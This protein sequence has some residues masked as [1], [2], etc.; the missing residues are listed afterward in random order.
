MNSKHLVSCIK[1]VIKSKVKD[2]LGCVYLHKDQLTVADKENFVTIPFDSGVDACVPAG[3]F[4][5]TLKG[6]VRPVFAQPESTTVCISEGDVQETMPAINSN[7]FP[8]NFLNAGFDFHQIG[9]WT[10][11]ELSYLKK[12]LDFINPR[13]P[14]EAV[15]GI[16]AA[17]EIAST[18]GFRLYH[19]RI[20]HLLEEIIIPEKTA[21]ILLSFKKRNWKVF[22]GIY[23]VPQER[24]KRGKKQAPPAP[25]QHYG[26]FISEDGIVISFKPI[27]KR[28]FDY[29]VVIPDGTPLITIKVQAE[30]LLQCLKPAISNLAPGDEQVI[31]SVKGKSMLESIN[32]KTGKRY[33]QEFK[34]KCEFSYSD[35]EH[36]RIGFKG[37][38]LNSILKQIKKEVKS[39]REVTIQ[40]YRATTGLIINDHYLL[41]SSPISAN[42]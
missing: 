3:K 32:S 42:S 12:A 13:Y 16:K 15:Q 38:Y 41:I 23:V 20:E 33:E 4:C 26:A 6:M 24:P 29:K 37:V 34:C 40:L 30:P 21:R 35:D 25:P 28:Y 5:K 39:K 27:Q 36:F 19:P 17:D 9:E 7:G 22:L 2:I 1:T 10:S 14:N 18:D 8:A 31:L 11:T